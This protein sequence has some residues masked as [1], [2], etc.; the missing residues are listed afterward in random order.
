MSSLSDKFVVTGVP[1]DP[2]VASLKGWYGQGTS[3]YSR[4][5]TTDVVDN[6]KCTIA[7]WVKRPEQSEQQGEGQGQDPL[8]TLGT[9]AGTNDILF[10][11]MHYNASGAG[12]QEDRLHFR[13]KL[14][15]TVTCNLFTNAR[16]RDGS[17]WQHISLAYDS[18]L[19]T[20]SDRIKFFINGERQTALGSSTSYP[21]QNTVLPTYNGETFY[22]GR[23]GGAQS[24]GAWHETGLCDMY[25]IDGEAVAPLNNFI[26]RSSVAAGLP[27]IPLEYAGSLNGNS[28]HLKFGSKAGVNG[29]VYMRPETPHAKIEYNS[30]STAARRM[31]SN[32]GSKSNYGTHVFRTDEWAGNGPG[33]PGFY[34]GY[35]PV[36][37]GPDVGGPF[38]STKRAIQFT[39]PENTG[40]GQGF[41]TPADTDMDFGTGDFAISYWAYQKAH[42]VQSW[43][44]PVSYGHFDTGSILIQGMIGD[45]SSPGSSDR[46]TQIGLRSGTADPPP[47][48]LK[49]R[50]NPATEQWIHY[51]W[52]RKDG[53]GYYLRN[54]ALQETRDMSAL[55]FGITGTLSV[56]YS[57]DHP[58]GSNYSRGWRG[59][60]EDFRW[61][62]GSY[63]SEWLPFK[64]ISASAHDVVPKQTG[65]T[66]DRELSTG[67]VDNV[68]SSP[69]NGS[70]AAIS[71]DPNTVVSGSYT[72]AGHL[73]IANHSD[74]ALSDND[75]TMEFWIYLNHL[76]YDASSGGASI[77]NQSINGAASD[78]SFICWLTNAGTI[79]WFTS[80]TAQD[81]WE[82]AI[83]ATTAL[84]VGSWYH[85]AFKRSGDTLTPYVNGTAGTSGSF[86]SSFSV[87]TSSSRPVTVGMQQGSLPVFF[88]GY[89]Q[90]VRI[91][92][93]TAITP[94]A[95]G[96]T[97]PLTAVTNTKL[98]IQSTGPVATPTARSTDVSGT[99]LLIQQL[100]TDSTLT[101]KSSEARTLTVSSHLTPA[102]FNNWRDG[103]RSGWTASTPFDEV[104]D[105]HSLAIHGP[106][107]GGGSNANS[108]SNNYAD[109][110]TNG[111]NTPSSG[112]PTTFSSLDDDNFT[113][114]GWFY[115]NKYNVDDNPGTMLITHSQLPSGTTNYVG[116]GLYVDSNL[117]LRFGYSTD[118]TTDNSDEYDNT[119][120]AHASETADL[121]TWH[122]FAV[123][124]DGSN[125]RVYLNG[126]GVSMTHNNMFS[127][128]HSGLRFG[129]GVDGADWNADRKYGA[130]HLYFSDVY[131]N[132][133]NADYTTADIDVPTSIR[134]QNEIA[135]GGIDSADN[136]NFTATGT[137]VATLDTPRNGENYNNMVTFDGSRSN[138]MTF[139]GLYLA[140]PEA[141]VGKTVIAA[142]GANPL[143]ST[144]YYWEAYGLDLNS[145]SQTLGVVEMD[146]FDPA[147]HV[148]TTATS[149]GVFVQTN[150]SSGS[151]YH[152]N[153]VDNSSNIFSSDTADGD[154]FQFAMDAKNGKLWFGRNGTWVGDPAAGTGASFTN[155]NTDANV[156]VP[157]CSNHNDGGGT[158]GKIVYN[159]GQ[160]QSFCEYKAGT[161]TS[162]N[163]FYYAPP[164]GFVSMKSGNAEAEV[165]QPN[166]NFET[167]VYNG[168]DDGSGIGGDTTISGL[169]FQPG[170]IW[171]RP[172]SDVQSTNGGGYE[173][174]YIFDSVIGFGSGGINVDGGNASGYQMPSMSYGVDSVNSNGFV[175]NGEETNYGYSD[176]YENITDPERYAAWCWKLGKT[177]SSWAGAGAD[178]DTEHYSDD[179]GISVL[180]HDNSSGTIGSTLTLNHSL[181]RK[182]KFAIVWDADLS[183][184]SAGHYVYHHEL[185][186]E[187]YLKLNTN[188]AQAAWGGGDDS[189]AGDLPPFPTNPAT[190]TTFKIGDA[191]NIRELHVYLFAEILGF[192][193]FGFIDGRGAAPNYA[194]MGFKPRFVMIKKMNGA[195]NWYIYDNERDSLETHAS[196]W[197]KADAIDTET[198]AG[199]A[200]H[201]IDFVSNG[202]VF[203][204]SS[205]FDNSTNGEYIYAAFAD[206]PWTTSRGTGG[207]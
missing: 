102:T 120:S 5:G 27:L 12:T 42:D 181:G 95:G 171:T 53:V 84:S 48:Y 179:T 57:D 93:G 200:S 136:G 65:G 206:K 176:D 58:S 157:A 122:H 3:A 2:I 150:A 177:G 40:T 76:S 154:V 50:D 143:S 36:W 63:P 180:R 33:D 169:Q 74:F 165:A 52:G 131:F 11:I 100:S 75:F 85:I 73:E 170:I 141:W 72:K 24:S 8:F 110:T 70:G 80:N 153:S 51:V 1:G 156:I 67:G 132:R 137:F 194:P 126:K 167:K 192:S 207:A 92:N 62:K 45:S 155:L 103:E 185:D 26:K 164:D 172:M 28:F 83:A 68:T 193:K 158:T 18:T 88:D 20:E 109:F 201:F 159:F 198:T 160:S 108:S 111:G 78:S 147:N 123:S 190:S 47:F 130:G 81:D 125:I 195:N 117:K 17:N 54:G 66:L 37:V 175:V 152:N 82:S 6:K 114:E 113:L 148:G 146:K 14:N 145:Y 49:D 139:C 106:T 178:P 183:F 173:G 19:S 124:G 60:L 94:P 13:V 9:T 23:L 69:P 116:W 96:P 135:N 129:G 35:G 133:D 128:S 30:N 189:Q 16:F 71:F 90:D 187:K 41:T 104:K 166:K 46:K 112:G 199:T 127:N 202:L 77:L 182:P 188:A 21:A 121:Y 43:Q 99:Q 140:K 38:T 15:D 56:G 64:D 79:S 22:A 4:A 205:D 31:I 163:E 186:D 197:A 144:K 89:L 138:D 98:L 10:Y 134:S 61:L 59:L 184:Y 105:R 34:N 29:D 151:L 204:N 32:A 87:P 168:G 25:F 44:A 115:C 142:W 191:L 174:N 161:D 55:D 91:V 149:W 118:G 39:G 196:R 86:T 203:R 162:Q 101:D 107:T 97:E 119:S 7:C